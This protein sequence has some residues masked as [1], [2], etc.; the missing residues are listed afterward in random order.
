MNDDSKTA[1]ETSV[2]DMAS[3]D[4]NA[5]SAVPIL[6][7]KKQKKRSNNKAKQLFK[8]TLMIL[9]SCHLG[10]KLSEQDIGINFCREMAT[11]S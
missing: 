10:G 4:D 1:Q 2:V 7:K 3:D 8:G 5:M 9:V 11:C 6:S